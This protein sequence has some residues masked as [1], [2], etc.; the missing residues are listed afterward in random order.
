[1]PISYSILAVRAYQTENESGDL[2][3]R[4]IHKS[5]PPHIKPRF[6]FLLLVWYVIGLDGFTLS[7]L[8]GAPGAKEYG[9]LRIVDFPFPFFPFGG[10]PHVRRA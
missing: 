4:T 9:V 2:V 1:M 8:L 7:V 3:L 5:H 6:S 10:R